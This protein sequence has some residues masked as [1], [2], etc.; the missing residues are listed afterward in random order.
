MNSFGLGYREAEEDIED[1]EAWIAKLLGTFLRVQDYKKILSK[2]AFS[3]E[4][5]EWIIPLKKK[6]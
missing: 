5:G 3:L 1:T 2:Q 6:V 4:L